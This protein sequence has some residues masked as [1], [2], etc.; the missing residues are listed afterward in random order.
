MPA[1]DEDT[2]YIRV[3]DKGAQAMARAAEEGY[4]DAIVLL[5]EMMTT[6]RP[7]YIPPRLAIKVFGFLE[8]REL[9]G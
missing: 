5:L 9:V 8:R 4:V 2:P 3:T 1:Q 7:E 6:I